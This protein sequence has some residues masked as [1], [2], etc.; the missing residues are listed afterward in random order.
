[1]EYLR[2][3][4]PPVPVAGVALGPIHKRDVINASAMLEHK[5]E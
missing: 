3:H 1:M 2:T 5:K 4:E